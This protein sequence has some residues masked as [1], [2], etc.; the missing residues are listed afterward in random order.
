MTALAGVLLAPAS[1]A[2]AAPAPLARTAHVAY[3]R[4]D[5]TSF[6]YDVVHPPG[7]RRAPIVV[8]VH[9]GGWWRGGRE[10]LIQTRPIAQAFARAG[11][12]AV[13]PDYRLACSGPGQ[14]RRVF[15]L[16]FTVGDPSGCGA[17][18]P[19][20]V[21]DVRA[22]VRHVRSHAGTLRVDPR[23]V[24]LVGVSAGGHLALLAA[25][26]TGDDD[27]HVRAVVDASGPTAT[28]FIRL[29]QARPKPP[30]RTIRAA[31][32]NA[33]GCHPWVCPGRWNEA[34]PSV[35]LRRRSSPT[36]A[37]LAIAGARETQVPARSMQPFVFAMQRRGRTAGLLTVGGA[38]HGSGCLMAPRRGAAPS[39]LAQTFAFLR[40]ELR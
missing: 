29:Q 2:A 36:F 10:D 35:Q 33:V 15:G 7:S 8:L 4:H 9:G 25:L 6:A 30:L 24:A 26:G 21:D 14:H 27:L 5:G 3:A 40:R 12:A 17:H 23:R 34:D 32:T 31:F 39:P 18:L 28:H 38:C 20:Q 19:D 16:S 37:L 22:T 1:T 13:V 11:F